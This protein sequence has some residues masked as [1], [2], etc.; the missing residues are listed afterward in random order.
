MTSSNALRERLSA[1]EEEINACR[2][3]MPAHSVKP[4]MMQALIDLEDE[5]DRILSALRKAEESG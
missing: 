2:A 1:L 5:R 4:S 3:Q